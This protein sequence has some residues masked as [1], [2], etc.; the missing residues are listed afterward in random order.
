MSKRK[1]DDTADEIDID[2]LYNTVELLLIE[3]EITKE[4]YETYPQC[5][6]PIIKQFNYLFE[7]EEFCRKNIEMIVNDLLL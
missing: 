7:T 5:I 2:E 4:M 6:Y 1:F 3:Y